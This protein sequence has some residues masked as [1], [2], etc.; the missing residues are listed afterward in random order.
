MADDWEAEDWEAEDFKPSL[1]AGGAAAKAG[2]YE[3]AGQALLAKATEP[4]MSKF[5]D[6]DQEEPEPEDKGYHI[7]PQVRATGRPRRATAARAAAAELMLQQPRWLCPSASAAALGAQHSLQQQQRRQL[8]RQRNQ[9]GV[10]LARTASNP[11]A[12]A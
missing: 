7:K 6:E 8:W 12:A 9:Q 11:A 3:T 2:E 4:D 5:E 1:P 10:C